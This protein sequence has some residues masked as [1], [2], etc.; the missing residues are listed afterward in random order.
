MRWKVGTLHGK[1]VLG[2]FQACQLVGGEPP[3]RGKAIPV[4]DKAAPYRSAVIGSGP[5]PRPQHPVSSGLEVTLFERGSGRLMNLAGTPCSK[6]T[7]SMG[8]F[9]GR[10]RRARWNSFSP[11]SS[12]EDLERFKPDL[13]LLLVQYRDPNIEGIEEMTIC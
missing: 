6:D 5:G 7:G 1:P 2:P 9:L 3:C 4:E 10:L 11:M 12:K 8:L 13:V